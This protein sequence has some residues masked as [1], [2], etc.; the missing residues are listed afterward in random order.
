MVSLISISGMEA[1]DFNSGQ[2]PDE[3]F[4]TFACRIVSEESARVAPVDVLTPDIRVCLQ[5]ITQHVCA[6]LRTVNMV[7]TTDQV[8]DLAC[9]VISILS[10]MP[11][12]FSKRTILEINQVIRDEITKLKIF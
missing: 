3:D 5:T 10:D 4:D 1:S 8:T 12:E 2:R 6:Q 9:S 7:L 11:G